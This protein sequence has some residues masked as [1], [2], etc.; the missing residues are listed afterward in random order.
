MA[1]YYQ[2]FVGLNTFMYE[3]N[4]WTFEY[5]ISFSNNTEN[6][7][8]NAYTLPVYMP[9]NH[10]GNYDISDRLKYITWYPNYRFSSI[11]YQL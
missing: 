1:K 7:Q 11:D 8:P 3:A 10:I 2:G 4:G 5:P 6:V 9:L